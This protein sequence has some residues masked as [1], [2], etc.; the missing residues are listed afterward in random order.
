MY[1]YSHHIG[2]FLKDTSN[3]TDEQAMAY[4][5]L[6]WLYYDSEKPLEDDPESLAFQIRSNSAIVSRILKHYFCFDSGLWHHKRIN[7]EIDAY[8]SKAEKARESANARWNNAN[9]KRTHYD[10]N[11]N[12]PKNYA[13]QEPRTNN[14]K[15]IVKKEIQTPEGVSNEVFNDFVKLRKGLKAPVTETAIKG[16]DREGRKAGMTLQEVM[17]LCCQNGWRGFKAEWMKSKEA[18]NAGDRNREVMSGLTRGLIG[19]NKN[20]GLL[21]K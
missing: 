3:L 6:I 9:A 1:Y 11:A 12:A 16:L 13:N 4:L 21:G 7:A 2:D 17:E 18:K 5:R 19:G 14:Q 20:V 15:P 8:H 10:R